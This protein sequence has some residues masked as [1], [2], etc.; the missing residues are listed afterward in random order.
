MVDDAVDPLV[1]QQTFVEALVQKVVVQDNDFVDGL[2]FEKVF[3]EFVEVGLEHLIEHVV[4]VVFAEL[5]HLVPGSV[6]L[7]KHPLDVALLG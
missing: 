5:E 6:G 3:F 2:H 7:R 1:R 4:E